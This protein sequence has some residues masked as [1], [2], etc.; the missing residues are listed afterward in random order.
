MKKEDSKYEIS[1]KELKKNQFRRKKS[2][3]KVVKWIAIV[4]II[5]I[6][7]AGICYVKFFKINISLK[8][9]EVIEINREYKIKDFVIELS[10][11]NLI[12]GDDTITFDKLG[13]K[14][15]GIKFK[16]RF[17][18]NV[19]KNI[20]V[21]V[22]DT[23]PPEITG[24][25]KI[26]VTKGT[27]AKKADLLKDVKAVDNSNE[28]IKVTIVGKYDLNDVGTYKLK[29]R[30]VDSSNNEALKDFELIVKKK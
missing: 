28:E 16:D 25:D 15:I 23:T 19:E 18:S 2:I 12:N 17:D 20:V 9:N 29:Y 8:D 26:T 27:S 4:L 13:T 14:T 6:I 1:K 22:K 24:K 5:L 30:A 11:G 21:D 3:S 10:N 7:C